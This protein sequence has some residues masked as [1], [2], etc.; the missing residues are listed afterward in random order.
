MPLLPRSPRS[1]SGVLLGRV[2]G[3]PILL[4][5]SWWLGAVVVTALYAPLVHGL[6][7][8]AGIPVT[9]VLAATLATLLA[10]SV[11]VHEL[12]HCAIARILGIP[13]RRVRLYLLGGVSELARRPANP[14]EE[15]LI[16]LAGPA[17]SVLLA[18]AAGAHWWA[19]RPGTVIWLLVAELAVANAVVAL[20]NLLPGLPLDGGRA[21]RAA[22]WAVTGRRR[23]GTTA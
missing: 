1:R 3:I 14:R 5:P 16:A 11:L 10:V 20:F 19:L 7:P 6:L 8:Q 4:T 13:V 15:G 9:V 21:L 23:T 22:V 17:V 18:L 12:G 2:A